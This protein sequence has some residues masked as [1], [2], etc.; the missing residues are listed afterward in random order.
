MNEI[1]RVIIYKKDNEFEPI[2][3]EFSKII[4]VLNFQKMILEFLNYSCE[5][6]KIINQC[7]V[8]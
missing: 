1:Y 7:E 2:T 3:L 4:D 6:T 8:L 5:I